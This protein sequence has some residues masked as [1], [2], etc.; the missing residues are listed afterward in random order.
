MT[1]IYIRRAKVTFFDAHSSEIIAGWWAKKNYEVDKIG[2]NTTPTNTG[3]KDPIHSNFYS[4]GRVVTL[5]PRA[6]ENDIRGSF[7][8]FIS[9]LK[10]EDQP[11]IVGRYQHFA[12]SYAC[13][14]IRQ[15]SSPM[16]MSISYSG[17]IKHVK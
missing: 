14:T 11:H 12:L 3:D 2:Q 17:E 16:P 9:L 5:S 6:G 1:W 15:L 13:A 10:S 7:D 8:G 4:L